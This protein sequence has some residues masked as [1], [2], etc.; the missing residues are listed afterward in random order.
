MNNSYLNNSLIP[1][2]DKDIINRI[3]RSTKVKNSKTLQDQLKD[4]ESHLIKLKNDQTTDN[5]FRSI[6]TNRKLKTF[7]GN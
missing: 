1:T 4:M 7:I 3:L 5:T 6:E 2:T